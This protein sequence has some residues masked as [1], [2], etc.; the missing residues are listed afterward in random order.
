MLAQYDFSDGGILFPIT[1]TIFWNYNTESEREQ[2][3]CIEVYVLELHFYSNDILIK[4][5]SH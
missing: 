5:K 1:Y 2:Q 4:I 3:W